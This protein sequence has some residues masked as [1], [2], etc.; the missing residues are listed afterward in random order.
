VAPQVE[1]SRDDYEKAIAR[2]LFTKETGEQIV[3]GTGFLVA[4]GYVLTCAHVVLQAL[5][6]LEDDFAAHKT[7]PE[8]TITLDF[9]P[10]TST[11]S[12]Q[13]VAWD[14]YQIH[15]GDLAGLRLLSLPPEMPKPLP[16]ISCSCEEIE[17]D[18]HIIFGFAS[19][20]GG[21]TD[22]YKPKSNA[23]GGR[24][25]FHKKD[26]PED[27]TIE[28]GYSGAPVW[29]T[30]RK[31]VVGMIATAAVSENERSKAYAI[32]EELLNPLV[33][34][35]F[36]R[37][38]YDCLQ[39]NLTPAMYRAIEKAFWLCDTDGDRSGRDALLDQ[40][41]HLAQ[42]PSRGWQQEGREVD[43]LT[44]WALLL[45]V[46]DGLPQRLVDDLEAW[47]A[48]RQFDFNE[49]YKQ[50]N[51]YRQERQVSSG[52]TPEHIMVQIKPDEE[53]T[54]NVKLWVWVIGDRDR[55]DPLNPPE[56]R[57]K[58][59]IVPRRDV[60][61]FLE[62]WLEEESD[63]D[64]PMLHC[65]VARQSLGWDL[66]AQETQDGFTLGSQYKLVMRTDLSQSP[67]GR[68]YY[69]RWEKQWAAVERRQRETA[70][71]TFVRG[72]CSNNRPRLFKQLRN[73]E[74]AILENLPGDQVDE[75]FQFLARKGCWPI[76]L[77]AR[78]HEGCEQLDPLLD[79]A[80]I[81]L[82]EQVY[83]VR[84]DSRLDSLESEPGEDALGCHVT[85]VWEDFKVIP[86]TWERLDQQ[87]C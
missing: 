6:I 44:Q 32:G 3:V 47:V 17:P 65:F 81:D 13:V 22:A 68:Q 50:A 63:L 29:N 66:D 12:A 16:L 60:P 7:Q 36:A 20:S 74:M 1:L 48:L 21:R 54:A 30:P 45:S 33:Q 73:A 26:D 25:Q 31:G 49:L 24:F 9:L 86:P 82:P 43:R 67:T 83:N 79:C 39:E 42:L 72:D 8:G 76:L 2:I 19:E 61:Q 58:D 40:L 51:R 34:T 64:E 28:P 57:L 69:S 18:P 87:V 70:R 35:L 11:I 85:L 71:S 56:P 15:R 5:G 59:E 46:M 27:D 4:P 37:S 41:L 77:W 14:P 10:N 78:H 38:L 55:Y 53:N 23:V 52:Y 62:I 84:L 80:V 75:I